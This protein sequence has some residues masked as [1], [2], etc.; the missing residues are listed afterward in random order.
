MPVSVLFICAGNLVY[1][2]VNSS[3]DGLLTYIRLEHGI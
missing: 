1:D 2:L 3:C